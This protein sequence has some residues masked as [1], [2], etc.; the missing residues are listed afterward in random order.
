MDDLEDDALDED[1]DASF[2]EDEVDRQPK[3]MLELVLEIE[4]N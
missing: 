3:V 2:E 1:S 4:L